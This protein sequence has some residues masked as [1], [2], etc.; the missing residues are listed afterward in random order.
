MDLFQYAPT[1]LILIDPI[2]NQVLEVNQQAENLFGLTAHAFKKLAVSQL[3]QPCIGQLYNFSQEV[4]LKQQ[5]WTSELFTE[6]K[7]ESLHLEVTAKYI[8]PNILL[9][10]EDASVVFAKRYQSSVDLSFQSGLSH[11]QKNETIF[12]EIERHNQLLLSAVGDG[13]YGVDAQGKTT[14]VNDAAEAILGWKRSELTGKKIHDVIHHSHQDGRHYHS[15]DCPI[16]AAFH[17]GTVHFVDN[18]VF[19]SK[20]GKAISVE[21]TST[22]VTDNGMLIGAVVI[23]RDVTER[24]KTQ[25]KLLTALAEVDALK[26]RLELENAYLLEEINADFNHHQI[27]GQSAVVQRMINQIELV[28][29]TDANVLI[30][31]ESGTGKELIA[32][33]LHETSRRKAR[34]LIRVNCAA[35]PAELFESEFFGHVKGAF[36]GAISDRLGRFELADGATIF[37]DEVGE[38]PLQLQSKLLRVLQEQQFERVGESKTRKVDVRVIAAT[39]QDLIK[40]VEQNKFREDLY[41]RLNVFP[42]NSPPLRERRDDIPLLVKHFIAKVAT[43]FNQ[44]QPQ[45]SIAQMQHLQNYN[46]PGNIRELENIIERQ[47]ILAKGGKLSF[48]FLAS[49]TSLN[50]VKLKPKNDGELISAQQQKLMEKANIENA[51][52]QSLGKIYG[53]NGAAELLGLKPTTLASKI[54]K[55]GINRLEYVA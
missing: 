24:K 50:K 55:Y 23:F 2:N 6:R 47:V 31:G 9:S 14:F 16:Y 5:A 8:A 51:L 43:R 46:W 48:D 21:Y 37:L 30:I 10:C 42:I 4:M 7:G 54:K 32:R 20:Q 25:A 18:E 41:F 33:A 1:A 40:L 44:P 17:D 36:S 28:G 11:W 3:F 53:E 15:Q 49:E 29:E 38:I 52:K 39:N 19:W 22:P 34:P 27:I 13:I 12:E 26:S 35:I 45:I